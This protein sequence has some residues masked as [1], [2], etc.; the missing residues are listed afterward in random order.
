MSLGTASEHAAGA[1][2]VALGCANSKLEPSEG[3]CGMAHFTQ[4]RHPPLQAF[5]LHALLSLT[6]CVTYDTSYRY[7]V[8]CDTAS[9]IQRVWH[10]AAV[11][12]ERAH[13]VSQCDC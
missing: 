7:T 2:R 1:G 9:T 13:F 5:I 8:L 4:S 10:R 6:V 11:Q 12:L 3:A